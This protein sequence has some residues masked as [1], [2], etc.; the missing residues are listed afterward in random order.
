MERPSPSLLTF[1]TDC[2]D[3]ISSIWLPDIG[4]VRAAPTVGI[5]QV[6]WRVLNSGNGEVI[7]AQSVAQGFTIKME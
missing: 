1:T 5:I 4:R 3:M 2:M 6:L 7:R